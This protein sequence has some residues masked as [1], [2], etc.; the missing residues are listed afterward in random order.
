MSLLSISVPSQIVTTGSGETFEVRGLTGDD[1][2][3]L[4]ERHIP[5]LTAIVETLAQRS[6]DQASL[7]VAD[8]HAAMMGLLVGAP[9]IVAEVIA[10]AAG[11]DP[12]QPEWE[13][14]VGIAVSLPFPVQA[15]ALHKIGQLSFTPDF[16]PAHL[17]S[18]VKKAGHASRI[19]GT[20]SVGI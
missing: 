6:N 2:V 17:M 11:T 7:S 16:T 9:Q 1:V 19:N 18:L 5:E 13:D 8:V 14:A 15:D 3:K 4:G 12:H 10:A 20:G